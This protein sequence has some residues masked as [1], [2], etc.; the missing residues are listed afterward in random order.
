MSMVAENL[1]RMEKQDEASK[2]L[3]ETDLKKTATTAMIGLWHLMR[4][5][6]LLTNACYAGSFETVS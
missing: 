2:L 4:D 5:V 6:I 3:F 1:R